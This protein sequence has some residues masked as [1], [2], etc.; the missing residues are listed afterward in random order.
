[1]DKLFAMTTL[2]PAIVAELRRL[3]KGD[4]YEDISTRLIYSTDASAYQEIPMAVVRPRDVQDL[5]LL[6]S[7]VRR[8]RLPVILR[9]A[10]TSL[11]GQVVGGGVVVD[12][13]T[14]LNKV[15]EVNVPE[16]WVMVEP[17]VV[18]DELNLAVKPHGL[19]F[20][21]ETSTSNRCTMGGMVGNNSCGSHSLVY[22]STRDHLLEVHGF[23]SNGEEVVFKSLSHGEWESKC[24]SETLEGDIYR[25]FRELMAD[26]DMLDEIWREYPHP[27]IHRRNTG[28]ALDVVCRQIRETGH[29]NLAPLIAG[30]EG[31]LMVMSRLKLSLVPLPP[32]ACGLL[33]V[34]LHSL[35]QA[36]DAN[37]VALTFSPVAVELMDKKVL[38]LTRENI[39]QRQ[40]RFFIEGDPHALLLVEMR[41]DSPEDVQVQSH[42]LVDALQQQRLGYAYPLLTGLDIRR[43]W[44]LRKAGLGVLS[45]MPGDELP[46]PVIEDTAVRVQEMGDYLDSISAMLQRYGKSCVYY[47]HIGSGELHLRPVLNMKQPGDVQMFRNIALDTA[48][49]VKHFRGSLSGEHGDGRLRGEF[50]PLMV[51]ER[52]YE[53]LRRLKSV[54]DPVNLFNPGKIVDAPSMDAC[55]RYRMAEVALPESVFDWSESGGWVQ[56]AERCNGSADCRKSSLMGG[57]MCPSFMALRNEKDSTRARANLLRHFFT[58]SLSIDKQGMAVVLEAL[59]FCLSC[60]ACKAECPSNVDMAKLKAE[61]LNWYRQKYGSTLRE[62]VFAYQPQWMKPVSLLPWFYNWMVGNQL[63]ASW[64]AGV[65]GL[66]ADVSLPRLGSRTLRH[67]FRDERFVPDGRRVA[68]FA[69][70]FTN[71]SDAAIG[72]KAIALLQR[73]GYRV[74]MPKHVESGRTFLSKGFLPD[75]RRVARKNVQLLSSLVSDEMPLVGVEPSAVLTFRDEYPDLVGSDLVNSAQSLAQH[76]LTIEEFLWREMAAGRIQQSSFTDSVRHVRYHVHCYQ[77]ALSDASVTGKVLSF[78]VNYTAEAIS[79]GCCGMAGSFGYEAEHADLAQRIGELRLFPAVRSTPVGVLV[80]AAGTSCRSHILHHTARQVQHPVEILYEAL[81]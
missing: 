13:S 43:V 33:C 31:T 58:G 46:V 41:G 40:N 73:L 52:V 29:I 72:M 26:R 60:K 63:M 4:V 3:L 5:S 15:L 53:L 78:P 47:G 22:G 71:Y 27:D 17:G 77:K 80:A 36:V 24:K 50:I 81:V 20:G 21:P 9:G 74:E 67:W 56:G 76:A 54:F 25:F 62:R 16:Q 69:D 66:D 39:V 48:H 8:H 45:N 59:D 68:F 51:G 34:H 44:D 75:A 57:V 65:L 7:F 35:R 28:Y 38:D 1:M 55:L 2:P 61:F 37:L 30:S 23:L 42:R 11:A 64:L 32:L 10:G 18:L 14:F 79:S 12:V 6:V 70:E 49:I 19:F